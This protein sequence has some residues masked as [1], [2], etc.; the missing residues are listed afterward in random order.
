MRLTFVKSSLGI[1][2]LAAAALFVSLQPAP[3][4]ARPVPLTPPASG[5]STPVGPGWRLAAVSAGRRTREGI[6]ARRQLL[7][8]IGPRGRR[9]R[10]LSV[11]LDNEHPMRSGYFVLADWS[12]DGR[13]ALLWTDRSFAAA[14][15]RIIDIPTGAERVTP[16]LRNTIGLQLAADGGLLAATTNNQGR[17]RLSRL[18]PD[19]SPSWSRPTS[20]GFLV[21]RDGSSILTGPAPGTHT[22]LRILD[23][24][25]GSVVNRLARRSGACQPVRWWTQRVALVSC[26]RGSSRLA[27]ISSST[28]R[29]TRLTA[30]RSAG[31]KDYGDTDARRTGGRLYLQANGPCGYQFVATEDAQGRP[32]AVPVPGAVGS[33]RL[34][35]ADEGRLLIEHAI[36][37]DSAPPHSVLA[38]F[39]PVLRREAVLTALPARQEFEQILNFGEPRGQLF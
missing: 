30:D 3:G 11:R 27:L 5:F 8:L 7:E 16:L 10:L 36:A 13:T 20:S 22:G 31:P 15:A 29:M 17:V 2:V 6:A 14:T 18:A 26:F 1:S 37:C 32:H 28:G 34:L 35:D 23:A 9:H 25:D 19:G 24:T 38:W 39:D 33:V 12:A 4:Q 21:S